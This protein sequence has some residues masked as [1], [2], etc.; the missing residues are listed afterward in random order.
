MDLTAKTCEPCRGGIPP[1]DRDEAGVYLGQVPAWTL[2]EGPDRIK[3][4]F[5][6][7]DFAQVLTFIG[8]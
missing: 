2:L 7:A 3:R 8:G 1:L 6:F 5:D 4:K